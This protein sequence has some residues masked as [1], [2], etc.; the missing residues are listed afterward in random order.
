MQ[1]EYKYDSAVLNSWTERGTVVRLALL[2]SLAVV[3]EMEDLCSDP[4]GMSVLGEMN[5]GVA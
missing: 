5:D 1:N 2:V 4:I 3:Y